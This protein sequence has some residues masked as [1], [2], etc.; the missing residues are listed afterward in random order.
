MN[1]LYEMQVNELLGDLMNYCT[2]DAIHEYY[3]NEMQIPD[4]VIGTIAPYL[5]NIVERN[6]RYL[7]VDGSHTFD[8]IDALKDNIAMAMKQLYDVVGDNGYVADVFEDLSIHVLAR[9][10]NGHRIDVTINEA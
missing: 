6:G 3:R 4:N 9:D 1:T 7:S 2:D 5:S 10:E 8:D